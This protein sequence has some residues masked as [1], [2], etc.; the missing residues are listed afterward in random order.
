MEDK[1]QTANYQNPRER[2]NIT[3]ARS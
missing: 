2:T 3:I 1:A